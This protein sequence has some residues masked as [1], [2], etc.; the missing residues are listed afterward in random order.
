MPFVTVNI[1]KEAIAG[2]PERIKAAISKG[3]TEAVADAVG[4]DVDATW[5]VFN[6]VPETDWFLGQKRVK[7][8]RQES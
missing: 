5:V 7:E 1:V 8:F 4:F 3:I 6:E 2:D